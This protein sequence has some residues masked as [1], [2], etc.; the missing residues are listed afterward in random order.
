[1]GNPK[2]PI[3]NLNKLMSLGLWCRVNIFYEALIHY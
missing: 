2:K 1:M 3:A